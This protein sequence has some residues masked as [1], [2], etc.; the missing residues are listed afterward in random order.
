MTMSAVL[1]ISG[2]YFQAI[3][4]LVLESAKKKSHIHTHKHNHVKNSVVV[5][6]IECYYVRLFTNSKKL[7]KIILYNNNLWYIQN[8][9]TF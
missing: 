9:S 1:R 4:P 6:I 3:D 7:A 8:T 2:Q 5:E